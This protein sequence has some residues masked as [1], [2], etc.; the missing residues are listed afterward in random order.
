MPRI[1]SVRGG[2]V[3]RVIE[4]AKEVAVRGQR[5]FM[6]V[7][8]EDQRRKLIEAADEHGKE[9]FGCRGRFHST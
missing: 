6:R 9:K 3:R 4:E 2:R 8:D 7:L 5:R 1:Q